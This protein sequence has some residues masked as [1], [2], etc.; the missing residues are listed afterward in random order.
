[1]VADIKKLEPTA[2]D[3]NQA[4]KSGGQQIFEVFY[5]TS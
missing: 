3:M 2:A 1:M 4:L 5:K